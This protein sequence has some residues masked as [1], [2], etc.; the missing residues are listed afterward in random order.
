[1]LLVAPPLAAQGGWDVQVH[2]LVLARDST[3]VA[4]GLGAGLRVGRGLRLGA[5]V[6]GGWMAPGVV[7]GRTEVMVTYHL[8][9]TRP[10]RAGWYVGGGLAAELARGRARGLVLALVG[11]EA[12]PWRGGGLFAEVGVGG[13]ARV[14]AGY[15]TVRLARR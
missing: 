8:Y 14:A 13:G 5:T 6:A 2:A 4:G 15:R 10:G 12:R 9:P 3:L 1:M 11:V 7:A